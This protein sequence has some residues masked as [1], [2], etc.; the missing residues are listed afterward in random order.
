MLRRVLGLVTLGA[1]EYSVF[2]FIFHPPSSSLPHSSTVPKLYV[3]AIHAEPFKQFEN[4][5][6]YGKM[7]R[8]G[9]VSNSE[10][11]LESKYGKTN[12]LEGFYLMEAITRC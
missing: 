4:L 8:S 11:N 6:T 2:S 3:R 10:V 7:C 5:Q 9:T 12:S 1:H